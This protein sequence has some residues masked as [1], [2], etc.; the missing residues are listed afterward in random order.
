MH[1]IYRNRGVLYNSHQYLPISIEMPSSGKAENLKLWVVTTNDGSAEKSNAS[2]YYWY[3]ITII[4]E[5]RVPSG[6]TMYL[7]YYT[8]TLFFAVNCI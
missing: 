8:A 7:W 3:V 5:V 2:H 4:R 1:C 6:Q